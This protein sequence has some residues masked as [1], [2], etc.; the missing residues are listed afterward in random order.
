MWRKDNEG[1]FISPIF[2][3]FEGR[4]RPFVTQGLPLMTAGRISVN[5]AAKS[6]GI[7]ELDSS[8]AKDLIDNE[9]IHSF[10]AELHFPRFTRFLGIIFPSFDS[11]SNRFATADESLEHI[12]FQ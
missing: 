10:V 8:I 7:G 4:K 5:R 6:A 2:G 12:C 3:N 9:N 1:K 11:N